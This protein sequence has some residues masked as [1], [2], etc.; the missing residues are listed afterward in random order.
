MSICRLRLAVLLCLATTSCVLHAQQPVTHFIHG[1]WFDGTRFVDTDFYAEAG[2]L[3]HHPSERRAYQTFDLHGGFVVPPYGDAHEH[4]F[5][6]TRGLADLTAQ[7]L[8]DGI[9]YAQGM[10]D[11]T[12]GAQEVLAAHLVN[13]PTTVDVTYAHGGLTGINGHPKEVYESL[14]N[15]FYYPSTDAQRTLVLN[16]HKRKGEAYW[17]LAS[18]A[19]LEA[20]WPKILA[21]KPDLIKVYLSDSERFNPWNPAG[22]IPPPNELWK[23]IDPA[24]VPLIVQKAHAAGLKV[25]AHVDTAHDVHVALTAGVDELGHMPGY[26]MNAADDPAPFH[27]ADSDI[28]LAARNHVRVQATAGI[29]TDEKTPPAD[30]AARKASQ[31]GNLRRLKAAGVPILI[32]SD[33][34]GSDS[35]HEADYLQSFNLWSNLEMLRMWS[36][37]TPQTIFP[38]RKIA[39]LKP[40]FE[41][42]FLVLSA[43]PLEH[44]PATHA[45][46]DR[47]KQ[48]V[49]LLP[50]PPATP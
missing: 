41:A 9:F 50:T 25:A 12:I 45:I 10:T 34:Y 43:N 32:G 8:H 5:D 20:A 13:T 23:G 19:D 22:P 28:A 1:H 2:T 7:Y 48:G 35:L 17:E 46:T 26:G 29:D 16:G 44:W 49:H 33:R 30:A 39:E 18:P 24:L 4:N 11:T 27:L 14:A 3:T 36:V 38:H 47:W 6:G 40:G 15:G 42:S 31:I 37:E 21:A